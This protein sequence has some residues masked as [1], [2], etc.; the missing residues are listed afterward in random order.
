MGERR[1]DAP[2]I[3]RVMTIAEVREKIHRMNDG[4][5][6]EV[7][8]C[9]DGNK[10]E[11]VFSVR[12]QMY[13]GV[14]GR[15]AYLSPDYSSDPWFTQPRAGFFDEEVGSWVSCFM[16]PERYIAWKQHITPPLA[17][18]RLGLPAR[19]TGVPNLFIVGTFHTSIQ[20]RASSNGVQIFTEGWDQGP[21]VESK[22]GSQIFGL[23][24]QAVAHFN[25]EFLWAWLFQWRESL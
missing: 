24:E 22:Y 23:T 20:A 18:E 16:H 19:P 15:G 8:R 2:L 17:G 14:D 11:M 1:Q 9:M 10:Q 5:Q 3:F 4:F 7:L 25:R 13:S 21:A 6:P 12:E